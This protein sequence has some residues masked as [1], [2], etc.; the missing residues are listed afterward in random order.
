M[1]LARSLGIA[2]SDLSTEAR[3]ARMK[4]RAARLLLRDAHLCRHV[5]VP[6]LEKN[7]SLADAIALMHG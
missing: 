3:L 2:F 4:H 5:S 6:Q 1:E 7:L